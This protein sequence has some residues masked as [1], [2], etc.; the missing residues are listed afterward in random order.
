MSKL[1]VRL[2]LGCYVETTEVCRL[3]RAGPRPSQPQALRARGSY[4]RSPKGRT[5]EGS[6]EPGSSQQLEGQRELPRVPREEGKHT[7]K[8]ECKSLPLFLSYAKFM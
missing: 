2:K 5:T 4:Q 8:K 3:R 7:Y 1:F 6:R